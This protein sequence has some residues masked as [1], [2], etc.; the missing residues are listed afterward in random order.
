MSFTYNDCKNFVSYS[1]ILKN[2]I[3]KDMQG[4]KSDKKG[5]IH[6]WIDYNTFEEKLT[7]ILLGYKQKK[8]NIDYIKKHKCGNLKIF[9]NEDHSLDPKL[10]K[11]K[12]YYVHDNGGRPFLVY[13]KNGE[14]LI[15]ILDKEKYYFDI[16]REIPKDRRIEYTKCILKF[17]YIKLFIGKSYKNEMTTFSGGY[18][19]RFDGNSLLFQISSKKYIS[20]GM[21]IYSF[22]SLD[23]IDMYVSPVGNNDVPYPFAV[24]DKYV[25]LIGEQMYVERDYFKVDIDKNSNLLGIFHNYPE[26]V[27]STKGK[28]K[29]LKNYK[30]LHERVD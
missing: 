29:K 13:Y 27:D 20:I 2:G 16:Y 28:P 23:S 5:Y 17:K 18:G 15:Y 8:P 26:L 6:K 14:A 21:S 11:Y 3:I 7:K 30:L 10:E 24:G 9:R 12:Y 19:K 1:K 22:T 4:L 25:Y